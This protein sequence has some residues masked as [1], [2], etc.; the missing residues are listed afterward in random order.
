VQQWCS[1][2]NHA[3]QAMHAATRCLRAAARPHVQESTSRALPE[4]FLTATSELPYLDDEPCLDC[5]LWMG[6]REVHQV[7]VSG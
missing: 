3:W 4:R 5:M 1:Q 6:G 7:A 2:D